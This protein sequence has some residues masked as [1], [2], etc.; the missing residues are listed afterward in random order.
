M[1]PH[2]VDLLDQ[3]QSRRKAEDYGLVYEEKR[4]VEAVVVKPAAAAAAAAVVVAV[5]ELLPDD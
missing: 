4:I 3:E 2:P 1:K 5:G